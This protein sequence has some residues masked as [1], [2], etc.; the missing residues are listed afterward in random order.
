MPPLHDMLKTQSMKGFEAAEN[1]PKNPPPVNIP[2]KGAGAN[3]YIRCPLPPFSTTSDTLRQFDETGA[4]PTRRVIPLPISTQVGTGT[5]VNNS[6]IVQSGSGGGSSSSTNKLT[7]ALVVVNIPLLSPNGTYQ[8]TVPLQS[9]S[10][11]LLQISST[12]PVEVRCYADPLTQA[13]DIVRQPD[14]A[15]PFETVSG[16]MTDVIFDQPPYVWNWQNRIGANADNPQTTNLYVTVINPSSTT[17]VPA[18]TIT[19]T[20]LPLES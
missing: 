7:S 5:T 2:G 15:V 17:S 1:I 12:D 9:K 11:Q 18:V 13:S 3:R 19:I 16:L 14:T 4:T 8:T 20:Y 6:T 10:F